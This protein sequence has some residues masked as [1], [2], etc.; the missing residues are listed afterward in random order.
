MESV[1]KVSGVAVPSAKFHK[2]EISRAEDLLRK[3]HGRQMVPRRP[4]R[5]R[6]EPPEPLALPC[7]FPVMS[8]VRIFE[9]ASSVN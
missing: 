7:T 9:I 1:L 3:R 6:R 8:V 4:V 2:S 5:S